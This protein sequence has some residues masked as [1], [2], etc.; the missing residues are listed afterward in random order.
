MFKFKSLILWKLPILFSAVTKCIF[1]QVVHR[2]KI[3][4]FKCLSL[5]VN[6]NFSQFKKIW[7]FWNFGILDIAFWWESEFWKWVFKWIFSLSRPANRNVFFNHVKWIFYYLRRVNSETLEDLM[8]MVV[9][10]WLILL[11]ISENLLPNF[12]QRCQRKSQ[13]WFCLIPHIERW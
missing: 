11:A 13:R 7:K 5:A 6:S 10:N 9:I 4:I 3:G 12:S 2:F 8:I 1:S